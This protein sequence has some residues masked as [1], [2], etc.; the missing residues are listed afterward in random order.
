M[1]NSEDKRA[2]EL[3]E[4]EKL[5]ATIPGPKNDGFAA[6]VYAN[7]SDL[8]RSVDNEKLRTYLSIFCLGVTLHMQLHAP[9]TLKDRD[10]WPRLKIGRVLQ[11][12]P[13][14]DR[15]QAIAYVERQ[16]YTA[17]HPLPPP[18]SAKK[19]WFLQR[20]PPQPQCYRLAW[21]GVDDFDVVPVL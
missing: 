1:A 4:I 16:H 19:K 15:A 6:S 3:K 13:E 18:P 5:C 21:N 8:Y 2:R 11:R 10:W 9:E 12:L 17:K 20:K 14:H 7:V